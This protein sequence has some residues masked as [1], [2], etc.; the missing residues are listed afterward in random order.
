MDRVKNVSISTEGNKASTLRIKYVLMS[1]PLV[2][3]MS[4][5]GGLMDR[6]RERGFKKLVLTDGYNQSWTLD[7]RPD[8]KPY[9]AGN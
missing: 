2:F 8:A 9:P 7:L 3:N 5:D 6:Y 4:Q 1:K